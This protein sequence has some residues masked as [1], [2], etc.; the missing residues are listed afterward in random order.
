M[1]VK[2]STYFIYF[3]SLIFLCGCGKLAEILGSVTK[4]LTQIDN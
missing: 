2:A 4:Q 3:A 1:I